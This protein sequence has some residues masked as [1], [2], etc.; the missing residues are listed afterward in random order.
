MFIEQKELHRQQ[1]HTHTH[2]HIF[3]STVCFFGFDVVSHSSIQTFHLISCH[4]FHFISTKHTK[5]GF[6]A[7][8]HFSHLQQPV[9]LIHF[10][11]SPFLA[12]FSL[13]RCSWSGRFYFAVLAYDLYYFSSIFILFL[14]EAVN[15]KLNSF[16][17]LLLLLFL[18]LLCRIKQ[19]SFYA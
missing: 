19:G 10:S 1:T 9:H 17:L 12:Q 18:F 5:Y 14:S 6:Q 7:I 3:I 8:Q 4:V 11:H 15:L 13:M 2:S 16:L